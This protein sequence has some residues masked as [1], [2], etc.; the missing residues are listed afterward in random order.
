MQRT[1]E[2]YVSSIL[3]MKVINPSGKVIGRLIDVALEPGEAL[4]IVTGLLVKRGGRSLFIHWQDV[5]VIN[6]IV[7]IAEDPAP[8]AWNLDHPTGSILIRRDI[9]DKQIVDVNGAK[10]VRVNDVKLSPFGEKLCLSAVDVGFG[11][12]LRRLGYERFW[13]LVQKD[14]QQVEIGWQF[15]NTLEAN[16]SGLTLSVARDQMAD[17]HP[18]DLAEILTNIPRH[19]IKTVL[20][21]LNNETAGE[22][23]HELD[24]ELRTQII[25]QLDSE[26]ASDI[27]EEMQPDEAADVLGDLSQEKARELLGLMNKDEADEIQELMVHEENTAGGLMTSEFWAVNATMTVGEALDD[28]SRCAAEIETIYYAYVLDS[29]ELLLGV[30]GLRELLI[31]EK[32]RVIGTLMTE[33]LKTVTVEDEPEEVLALLAKYN[34][35]AIPVID[36]ERRMV[37]VVTIDDVVEL[38]LPYALKRRRHTS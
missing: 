4:P 15:V 16:A 19:T 27:L 34:L 6:P 21:A 14:L 5:L 12:L 36:Q 1:T 7:L 22:A 9:L 20:F 35:I 31:T 24:P 8:E 32:T 33:Q 29:N 38:F 3:R 13:S 10:V 30:V 25:N 18:A 23:L 11:G 37:G 28:L 2:L 26:Q 17:L